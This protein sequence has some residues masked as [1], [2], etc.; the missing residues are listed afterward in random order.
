MDF[1]T[2][3]KR[4]RCSISEKYVQIG[5]RYQRNISVK[6]YYIHVDIRTMLPFKPQSQIDLK[7]C[8]TFRGECSYSAKRSAY[9]SIK[10]SGALEMLIEKESLKMRS[11]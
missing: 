11:H 4:F 9:D 3:S 8:L 10:P 6:T 1:N 7:N 5:H 2:F